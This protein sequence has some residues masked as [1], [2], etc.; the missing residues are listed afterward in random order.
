MSYDYE[1]M[2]RLWA[3]N[4]VIL[5]AQP[6]RSIIDAS[7]C[8]LTTFYSLVLIFATLEIP[9]EPYTNEDCLL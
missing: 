5:M 7:H 4:R 9:L 2:K 1:Q 6:L 8:K 3:D